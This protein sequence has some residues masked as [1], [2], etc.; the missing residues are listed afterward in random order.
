MSELTD[1]GKYDKAA[2]LVTQ[3]LEKKQ[4]CLTHYIRAIIYIEWIDFV[5]KANFEDPIIIDLRD[6]AIND[7]TKAIELTPNFDP[8]YYQLAKVMHENPG[9]DLDYPLGEKDQTKIDEYY[10]RRKQF[11]VDVLRF[12]N[13][14]I[15]LDPAK[16]DYYW[17]RSLVYGAQNDNYMAIGDMSSAIS[18]NSKSSQYYFRRGYLYCETQQKALARRDYIK[19][20]DISG[21][22]AWLSCFDASEKKDIYTELI[23][24][25][26]NNSLF[27]LNRSYALNDMNLHER[28]LADVNLSIKLKKN[29]SNVELRGKIYQAMG[30][31]Q[32]AINDY[33]AVLSGNLEGD[34]VNRYNLLRLRS[35]CHYVMGNLGTAFAD[36][37]DSCK[38]KDSYYAFGEDSCEMAKFLQKELARGKKWTMLSGP[39]IFNR[40]VAKSF[41]YDKT[42]VQ[43][44]SN[45]HYLSWFRMEE[46]KESKIENMKKS[47]DAYR[48]SKYNDY[49]HSL[50]L[51][52]INCTSMSLGEVSSIDYDTEGNIIYNYSPNTIRLTTSV[53]E[54]YGEGA[55]RAICKGGPSRDKSVTRK[56]KR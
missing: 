36:M 21:E 22:S 54:S 42:S 31:F 12:I 32:N 16:A 44:K 5:K 11:N 2:D 41:Y 26:K 37:N 39:S 30:K 33:S 53:P 27:Y 15:T 24:R 4:D 3:L 1:N 28:A 56:K 50:M 46:S 6:N 45:G 20:M 35:I 18:L 17:L 19:A 38:V 48:I 14:A 52:E 7:L 23:K 43:R 10:Q 34:Y 40:D 47:G 51:W 29:S 49:S 55:C 13:K 8:S 25:H 9:K